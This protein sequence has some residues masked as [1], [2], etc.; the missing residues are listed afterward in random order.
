MVQVF[1]SIIVFKDTD[2]ATRLFLRPLDESWS[3]RGWWFLC[4]V[5]ML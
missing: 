5:I 3:R 1:D 4:R 2:C